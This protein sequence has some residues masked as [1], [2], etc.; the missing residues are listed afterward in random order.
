MPLHFG[1]PGAGPAGV[2]ED[3]EGPSPSSQI[4]SPEPKAHRCG[5]C[6]SKALSKN[7]LPCHSQFSGPARPARPQNY[8]WSLRSQTLKANAFPDW[9]LTCAPRA[10]LGRVVW[11][12]AAIAGQAACTTSLHGAGL[13]AREGP[14]S[15]PATEV[16][17]MD[18]R[19][20]EVSQPN[21]PWETAPD[22]PPLPLLLG[23]SLRGPRTAV[24]PG[25]KR[26]AAAGARPGD[27]HSVA[28]AS[29]QHGRNK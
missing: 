5:L 24:A 13:G 7:R 23:K 8:N 4:S 14:E 26:R 18:S 10:P 21:R 16:S 25:S 29:S 17:V 11:T 2:W 3:P 9:Q 12:E 27:G 19:S 22:A 6:Q 20:R 28:A 1:Q 15:L